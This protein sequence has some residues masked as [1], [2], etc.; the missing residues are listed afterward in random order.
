MDF[1]NFIKNKY[2][3]KDNIKIYGLFSL[4]SIFLIIIGEI[5]FSLILILL[6]NL[7]GLVITIDIIT[8]YIKYL[9]KHHLVIKE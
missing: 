1:S 9:M 4:T 5:R 3:Q 8:K 7:L 6:I 2:N